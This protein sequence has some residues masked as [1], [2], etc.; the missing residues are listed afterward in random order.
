MASSLIQSISSEST[1]GDDA[2]N[3]IPVCAAESFNTNEM[4]VNA[5]ESPRGGEYEC[6]VGA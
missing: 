3:E 1:L 4:A 6:A 5:N 2:G